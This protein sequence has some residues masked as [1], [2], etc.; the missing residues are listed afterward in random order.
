MWTTSFK[1]NS[2]GWTQNW[3]WNQTQL[4]NVLNTVTGPILM[5]RCDAPPQA[6]IICEVWTITC[7]HGPPQTAGSSTGW[8]PPIPQR[9][10]WPACTACCYGNSR[11]CGALLCSTTQCT[12]PTAWA[13]ASSSATLL[14]SSRTRTSAGS[15]A[16]GPREDRRTPHN[17]VSDMRMDNTP[18]LAVVAVRHWPMQGCCLFVFDRC[19]FVEIRAA[20]DQF[21]RC[22][23]FTFTFIVFDLI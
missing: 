9:K 19:Q 4:L 5:H 23:M 20:D 3:R 2:E 10:A 13:S 12:M 1:L 14:A 21:S 15:T 11:I 17:P 6:H 7:S 16:W 8:S 22:Q 18:K